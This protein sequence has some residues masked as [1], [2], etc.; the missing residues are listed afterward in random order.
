MKNARLVDTRELF[1]K[2]SF[3]L[4][5]YSVDL[6]PPVGLSCWALVSQGL[7]QG[8]TPEAMF[9]VKR[10]SDI[11]A[12]PEDLIH[13]FRILGDMSYDE[14]LDFPVDNGLLTEFEEMPENSYSGVVYAPANGLAGFEFLDRP[15]VAAIGLFEHEIEVVKYFGAT[16]MLS[17][18]G[19]HYGWYPY[20]AVNNPHREVFIDREVVKAMTADPIASI[21]A[22]RSRDT[23]VYLE[24]A[25]LVLETSWRSARSLASGLDR[26]PDNTAIRLMTAPSP[27][28]DA[29]LVW[30]HGCEEG[31]AIM[32][33]PAHKPDRI[34]GSFICLSGGQFEDR[35]SL[36]SD[37]YMVMLSPPSWSNLKTA[38]KDN[39][40]LVIPDIEAR[41]ETVNLRLRWLPER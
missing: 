24:N 23:C 7:S 3:S 10:A 4:A 15:T 35:A 17:L 39:A 11:D 26:M 33:D 6:P 5:V 13:F 1:T 37:G 30:R 32:A 14:R 40:D 28:A 9:C 22:V 8:R 20:P 36:V 29:T 27:A 34:L 38:L 21:L 12:F 2:R 18:M 19:Q 16:R 25:D 31:S 41:E